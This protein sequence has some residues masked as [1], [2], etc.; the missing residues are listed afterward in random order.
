MKILA[1][2]NHKGGVGKTTVTRLASEHF[3]R[4]G[5]RVLG[6]DTD[7]QCNYSARF[8]DMTRD[9]GTRSLA[10]PPHPDFKPQ[11]ETWASFPS[12]PPGYWSIAQLY[13]L[14]YIEPYPTRLKKLS[15]IPSHSDDLKTFLGEVETAHIENQVINHLK[16]ILSDHYF[17][18]NFDLIII[19]TPTQVSAL[20][21]SVL[22]AATHL[23][24]PTQLHPNSI[25]GMMDMAQAWQLERA[26]RSTDNPLTITGIL[27]TR[28]NPHAAQQQQLLRSLSQ[29]DG[30]R[31]YLLPA[32]RHM[33]TYETA[34]ATYESKSLFDLHPA[35]P[36]RKNATQVFNAIKKGLSL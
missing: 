23:L 1:I 24:I 36:C 26:C 8:L 12:A 27:P 16:T 13:S 5:K 21:R 17:A 30:T 28:Y 2:M 34:S 3:A 9:P 6:I 11:N 22:H 35:N 33:T 32:M 25:E 14:G 19:D 31:R 20:T 4:S 15:I 10:P 29:I 18:L 7:P